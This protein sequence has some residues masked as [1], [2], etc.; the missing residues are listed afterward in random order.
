MAQPAPLPSPPAGPRRA[1][2][3]TS[4]R[5]LDLSTLRAVVRNPLDAL[6]PEVFAAPLVR[7]VGGTP[8]R[9]YVMDPELIQDVLVRRSEIFPKTPENKRVLGRALGD[10]LLTAE[11]AHWRWQRRAAAPAFQP[12]KL[13]ALA[14]AMLEAARE[15]RDRWLQRP[16]RP[17]RVNHEMMRTTFDI[18]LATMLSGPGSGSGGVNP[19]RFEAAITDTVTPIGWSLA[20]TLLRL[21]PWTP[22]PGK[23]RARR[24]VDYLRGATARLA[25]ERRTQGAGGREDLLTLLQAGADPET[26][27]SMSDEEIVDNLL[28]FISAGHE[29]TALGLAWTLHLLSRHP[30][31]EARLVAEVD[32]V[33]GGAEVA[34]E[35]LPRLDYTRQ[36]F[37]EAMRLYP[38]APLIS[39]QAAE[40]T[41][42]GAL[43]LSAG[44]YLVIPIYALHRHRLLWDAPERFDPDRFAP[45]AVAA[46][47][48]F[49]FMPFGGG[50][51][52]CIG[53]AFAVQE[54]VAVLA[55]LLQRLRM[56]G[57][58][59]PS[60]EAVM[61]ITLRPSPELVMTAEPR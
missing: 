59:G 25:A 11:G 19:A 38:P 31:V 36:V 20:V 35:H 9:W 16:G 41:E 58:D 15:T 22:Y 14:P 24:A 5:R 61:R 8:Q 1:G 40:T 18:I 51:R 6:P 12:G 53:G 23:A 27:R 7:G 3:V 47:H 17:L 26:G 28:T 10:G 43:S 39:R 57:V 54:G 44:D 30:E 33:T 45:E 56:H 48:R 42:L 13:A 60:P 50:P 29:T 37:N 49:S 46:R 4:S 32:A 2:A 21:P 55:V 34:P 52:V